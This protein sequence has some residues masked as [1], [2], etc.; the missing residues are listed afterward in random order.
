M[1]LGSSLELS[2]KGDLY[3]EGVYFATGEFGILGTDFDPIQSFGA[4]SG[5]RFR[6]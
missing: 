4:R 2:K 1:K 6:F 3:V 5:V